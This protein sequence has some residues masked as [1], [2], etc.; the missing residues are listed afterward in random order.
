MLHVASLMVPLD[1]QQRVEKVALFIGK[2]ED[3]VKEV[4][5]VRFHSI[6]SHDL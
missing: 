2:D 3:G 6:L 5:M 1:M 4:A